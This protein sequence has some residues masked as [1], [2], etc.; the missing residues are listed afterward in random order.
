[1]RRIREDDA[2]RLGGNLVEHTLL[3]ANRWFLRLNPPIPALPSGE[4]G[5]ELVAFALGEKW[6]PAE[7]DRRVEPRLT[8]YSPFRGS[9][10]NSLRS[11]D[12]ETRRFQRVLRWS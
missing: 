8:I 6:P 4:S 5:A 7:G 10:L 2:P 3:D 11:P 9:A 1:V 12:R